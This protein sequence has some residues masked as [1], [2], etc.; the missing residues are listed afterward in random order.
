MVYTYKEWMTAYSDDDRYDSDENRALS[1]KITKLLNENGYKNHWG[2]PMLDYYI[3]DYYVDVKIEP[4]CGAMVTV[5]IFR[6]GEDEE[7]IVRIHPDECFYAENY[8]LCDTQTRL[9][10]AVLNVVNK[11]YGKEG[12]LT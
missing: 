1:D 7:E 6:E 3:S 11:V 5:T 12:E 2:E 4:V 9:A 10:H 8:V